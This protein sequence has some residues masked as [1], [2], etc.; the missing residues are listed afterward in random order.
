MQEM[1]ANNEVSLSESEL[2]ALQVLGMGP[3]RRATFTRT[4]KPHGVHA[5]QSQVAARLIV[6]ELAKPLTHWDGCVEITDAGR[7]R[8]GIDI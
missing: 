8:L 6:K 7:R 4:D 3:A 2:R 1:K 5:V